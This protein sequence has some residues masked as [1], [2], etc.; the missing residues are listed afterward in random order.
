MDARQHIEVDMPH[1]EA[2]CEVSVTHYFCEPTQIRTVA[3]IEV[4]IRV[5]GSAVE[6]ALDETLIEVALKRRDLAHR[7]NVPVA[8]VYP[9]L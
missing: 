5:P 6:M 4:G 3:H 8:A 2:G 1:V 9:I 7:S